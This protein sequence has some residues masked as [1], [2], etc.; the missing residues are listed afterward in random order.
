MLINFKVWLTAEE[1]ITLFMNGYNANAF[2]VSISG[3]SKISN[4]LWSQFIL[5]IN[6]LVAFQCDPNF[7]VV[8]V[9]TR[10]TV[11]ALYCIVF[12]Y[13][14]FMMNSESK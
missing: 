6:A 10:K 4:W 3:I 11:I 12:T 8:F 1:V 13:K 14:V 2:S 5:V 7:Y 9:K